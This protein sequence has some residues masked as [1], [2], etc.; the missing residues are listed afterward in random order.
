MRHALLAFVI[1]PGLLC[2]GCTALL[3]GGAAAGGYVVGQDDRPV[4]QQIDDG[5]ITASVK[6]RLLKDKYAPGWRID[7]DTRE[8]VVTL[9]G[10]VKSYVARSQ[11]E[12]IARETDGVKDVVNNLEVIDD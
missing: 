5:T 11:A 6:A 4:S 10:R 3:I 1:V 12:K 9:N 7:V 8:S 2:S